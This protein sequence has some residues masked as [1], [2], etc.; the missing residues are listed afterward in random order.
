MPIKDILKKDSHLD[1]KVTGDDSERDNA[2][3]VP[4]GCDYDLAI[5]CER[6][7]TGKGPCESEPIVLE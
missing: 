5:G 7:L 6:N 2:D 1:S 4:C 3:I